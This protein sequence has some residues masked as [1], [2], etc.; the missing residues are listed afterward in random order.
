M[1]PRLF[2]EVKNVSEDK[3]L[4]LDQKIKL[5]FIEQQY[6]LWITKITDSLN[7]AIEKL[8]TN[9]LDAKPDLQ[10]ALKLV[11]QYCVAVLDD[12][13][14][15]HKMSI[16]E[17]GHFQIEG[18]EYFYKNDFLAT[19]IEKIN[20]LMN[21]SSL[22]KLIFECEILP[23][24]IAKRTSDKKASIVQLPIHDPLLDRSTFTCVML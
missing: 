8:K 13:P 12:A 7:K 11:Q 18:R 22:Q 17:K 24:H 23:T 2:Q 15:V 20:W 4:T 19:K 14:I 1:Q 10:I 16:D 21:N 5:E 6:S 9:A 3:S